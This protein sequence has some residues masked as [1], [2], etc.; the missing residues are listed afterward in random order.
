MESKPLSAPV[1]LGI[2]LGTQSVRVIAVTHDGLIEAS[3]TERLEK[4]QPG[5]RHEQAPDSWWQATRLCLRAVMQQLGPHPHIEGLAVDAT[6]GTITLVDALGRPLTAGLMYD[7]GR[8]RDEAAEA[9]AAGETLWRQM[10]YR[11]QASW[12]LPKL[13]WLLRHTDVPADAQLAHQ[14]DVINAHL[15][16]RR[17]A[18]DSSHA[19]KTGYD[20]IRKQWPYAIFEALRIP[21]TLLPEV[22]SPGIQIGE[23]GHEAA[24]ETGLP[25]GTPIFS[26]M[27]DGCAAQIASGATAPGSWN[28]VIGTTLV[29]KGVTRE[30]LHDPL[31]VVYSHRSI[32]G[33]WLPGGASSTGA[34]AIAAEFDASDLERLNHGAIHA[35]PARTVVYPLVGMG[36]RFPFAVP[37][38]HGFT[39]VPSD[40]A[41]ISIEMRYRAILQGLAMLERLSFDSLKQ[42]GAE[43]DGR[44]SVSGGAVNSEALN[45]IRADVL[46]RELLIPAVTEG[47]FGM[48]V[49][50]AAAQSSMPIATERMTRIARTVTPRRPFNQYAAQYGQ[51][52]D[53]LSRRGWLPPQLHAAART[54]L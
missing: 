50:V 37:E 41:P 22:V 13:M 6:S 52:V 25:L 54:N 11:M 31:G 14:N 10:S 26:G 46:E 44:F 29:V 15:A 38:A 2:D 12:A 35:K 8:A 9:N 3:A 5:L 27:T 45:Q 42:L 53:E 20:L 19:L 23:S 17:L 34:A 4:R 36:E 21:S 47:A 48:A 39:L 51:F 33:L 30:L 49:L 40:S 18:A 16:G 28:T 32:D 7:D 43:T 24:A 1:Y